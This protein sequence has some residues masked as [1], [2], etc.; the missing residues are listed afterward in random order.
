MTMIPVSLGPLDFSPEPDLHP[1]YPSSSFI[2]HSLSPDSGLAPSQKSELVSH[3]L[4]RACVFGDLSL[5]Q[6]LLSDHQSQPYVDLSARD[7]DGLSLISL[8]ILGFGSESERDV[9]R[10][11]CV[12]LLIAQGADATCA[13]KGEYIGSISPSC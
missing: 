8:A 11:E 6:Y 5:L 10:E 9:E 2:S 1:L 7:E 3:S 12:R 13:D 4:S